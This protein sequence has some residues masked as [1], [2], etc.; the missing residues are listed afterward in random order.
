MRPE[1]KHFIIN[2]A[3]SLLIIA[4]S[5]KAINGQ[6][7][8]TFDGYLSDMQSLYRV[9][10]LDLLWENSLHNRLNLHFYPADWLTG[11]IQVRSRL[12]TGN[13]ITTIPGYAGHFG[14]DNGFLDLSLSTDGK[15][16]DH[17]GYIF[18]SGIDRLWLQFTVGSFE[19]K[20]GRQRINWGQ[21]FVWN[22]NDIFNSYS[23]FEVDYPERPGSDAISL[24]YY[25]GMASA[26]ELAVKTDSADRVTA[27][28]YFR[29]NAFRYDLQLIAGIYNGEDLMLG[30][31]WSG[32]IREAGF[33]GELSYFR[34]LSH[35]TDTAGYLMVSAGLD[36]TFSNSLFIQ[37]ELLYSAFAESYD[38]NSIMQF[39]S[40]SLD[41]KKLG[42][43]SWSFFTGLNYPFTPIFNGG[44]A[45]MVY[46][47]LKGFY[48]GPNTDISLTGNIDLSAIL[49]FFSAEFEVNGTPTRENNLFGFL[50]LKWNF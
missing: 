14:S 21:T 26:I 4:T 8:L 5:S 42:F 50:R 31:G 3:G 9:P 41:V 27:A 30:T 20:I 13:T 32:N 46:P 6:D 17:S 23:Y 47:G 38:I 40:G 43:T 35:F 11:T 28:A 33:R 10:R 1:I 34:D 48:L 45:A 22:P 7:K 18:Y 2:V 16:R 44:L 37:A 24:K 25:P 36:Y 19:A 12:I 15:I 29:T 39:Y 49:Q